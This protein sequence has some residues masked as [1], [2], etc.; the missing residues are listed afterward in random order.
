MLNVMPQFY[1]SADAKISRLTDYTELIEEIRRILSDGYTHNST[2]FLYDV[3]RSMSHEDS[4]FAS[5]FHRL[6]LSIR[7][8]VTNEDIEA[9]ER[10]KARLNRADYDLIVCMEYLE[11]LRYKD[12]YSSEP[13][14][15]DRL[16]RCLNILSGNNKRDGVYYLSLY[17]SV[18]K[19][20]LRHL[21]TH[22]PEKYGVMRIEAMGN[23]LMDYKTEWH[24]IFC[25][26][27]F[28]SDNLSKKCYQILKNDAK[29][30]FMKNS[31]YFDSLFTVGGA[32]A[33]YEDF[34]SSVLLPPSD[35]GYWELKGSIIKN[36]LD[37]IA[38]QPGFE[39]YRDKLISTLNSLPDVKVDLGDYKFPLVTHLNW[40]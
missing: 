32:I 10:Y 9:F 26:R 16:E 18:Y 33:M 13:L 4:Y 39:I 28:L 37:N 20:I 6:P 8:D 15:R 14:I 12:V 40:R 36:Y 11:Q 31:G 1:D 19:W 5:Y 23:N 24:R 2:I 38:L 3:L 29:D 21:L 17:D 22:N 35:T 25:F 34:N 27:N 30:L 7:I